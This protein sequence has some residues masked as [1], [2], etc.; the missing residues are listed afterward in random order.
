MPSFV[1]WTGTVR[2]GA[3]TRELAQTTDIFATM[4]ALS[5][6][7][8]PKSR[9]IDGK[10]ITPILLGT[11]A[12]AHECL[13]QYH[14]GNDLQAVRCGELKCFFDKHGN[15]TKLFNLTADIAEQHPIDS[16]SPLW[17]LQTARIAAAREKHLSTV[18]PV[19]DQ[20]QLG[21]DP[22]FAI[23][24]DLHSIRRSSRSQSKCAGAGEENLLDGFRS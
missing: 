23:C 1:R 10:D 11:G 13:F 24:A 18:R 12:S 14:A 2:A 9:I 21:N 7:K 5:G 20:I 17:H 22:S 15:P 19:Q 8:P 4:M 6:A 3:V 16:Q